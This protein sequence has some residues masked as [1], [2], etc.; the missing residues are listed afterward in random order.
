LYAKVLCGFPFWGGTNFTLTKRFD[1]KEIDFPLDPK[2]TF[3]KRRISFSDLGQYDLN[4]TLIKDLA[5]CRW[6]KPD[7]RNQSGLPVP[8]DVD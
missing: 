7:L 1:L 4:L 8:N 3:L 2:F 6:P 5:Q